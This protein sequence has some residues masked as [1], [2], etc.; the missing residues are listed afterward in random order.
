MKKLAIILLLHIC[1]SATKCQDIYDSIY[2]D[3]NWRTFNIH[4]PN[5]YNAA[6]DYPLVLGFHGGQQAANSSL[7]WTVFAFQSKLSQKADS[8]G[9]IVVYPE[10]LVYN[11]NR[12]WNA[13]DCC[14]PAMNQGYD[15]VAFVDALLDTLFDNYS[16]DTNRVY[17]TGSSNGGMLCYRLACE[18]SQRFAAIAPNACSQ[19]YSPC[20]PVNKVP[21][22]SFHS[23]ADPIVFY[24]GGFGGNP[25]LA[26]IFFP[27]QDST[28]KIW[29]TV[30][31]CQSR[32]TIVN[33]NGTNYDFIK[34][35]NCD[36]NLELHHYAT[37]DGS[38]SWPGGNPNN[39]PV[40]A[41]ISATDLLWDFFQNYSL[42]CSINTAVLDIDKE[43]F[44]L[45]PNPVRD[46]IYVKSIDS[47]SVNYKIISIEG[48]RVLNGVLSAD[49]YID[50][51][52]L[53]SGM[54]NIIIFN[55][56]NVISGSFKIV[57]I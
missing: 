50:V 37:T 31:N 20:N 38:H 30:N 51:S 32:D 40:S 15:D 42:G 19:M 56:K 7:G 8:S 25:I 24:N 41:Q 17:A 9:F 1:Y 4:L 45:Y 33:G 22:I 47:E 11:Q 3:G 26:N 18:L 39:N 28:I 35:H 5:G 13:G 46:R 27:S 16:V 10:G 12:T 23:K 36:C 2:V 34:I 55:K 6:I 48:R 57:K 21:V 52:I 14:M 49:G 53:N 43:N 29:S 44:M 54:Y